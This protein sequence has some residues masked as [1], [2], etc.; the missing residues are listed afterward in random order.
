[1]RVNVY[2]EDL[3]DRLQRVTREVDGTT[4]YGIRFPLRGAGEA[5]GIEPAVTLWSDNPETLRRLMKRA[6]EAL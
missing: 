4:W 2:A 5:E 1:M 6:A 3:T